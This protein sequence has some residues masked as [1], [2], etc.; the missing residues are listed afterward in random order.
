M[1]LHVKFYHSVIRGWDR[2]LLLSMKQDL[3]SAVTE[4][5][6]CWFHIVQVGIVIKQRGNIFV[7]IPAIFFITRLFAPE[8][9]AFF[10]YTPRLPKQTYSYLYK[11]SPGEA[12]MGFDDL[13][14]TIDFSSNF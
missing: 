3:K 9:C 13:C 10:G 7:K 14:S 4:T 2:V 5:P 8:T 1:S 11:S 6:F 12:D